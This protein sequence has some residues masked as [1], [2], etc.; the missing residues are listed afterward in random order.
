MAG[1]T[2][3]NGPIRYASGSISAGATTS[4]LSTFTEVSN[5]VPAKGDKMYPAFIGVDLL[6]TVE[7][8]T[9]TGLY[10]INRNTAV[11]ADAWSYSFINGS[12]PLSYLLSY[13]NWPADNKFLP[14]VDVA[15]PDDHAVQI[16]FGSTIVYDL[17]LAGSSGVYDP[18]GAVAD[19]C[20]NGP[21]SA[22]AFDAGAVNTSWII[23]IYV[24]NKGQ[25]QSSVASISVTDFH[26]GTSLLNTGL[27]LESGNAV[28]WENSTNYEHDYWRVPQI[29]ITFE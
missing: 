22:G 27:A 12:I 9:Y 1:C 20:A 18:F 26:T 25:T 5:A 4:L 17:S 14:I 2:L 15:A 21:G 10:Y 11:G 28:P 29:N 19:L 7:G 8:G 24:Q 6:F 13:Q 16:T 23:N 3:G